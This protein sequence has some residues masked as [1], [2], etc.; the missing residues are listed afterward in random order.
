MNKEEGP[1]RRIPPDDLKGKIKEIK[2]KG[3]VKE[4]DNLTTAGIITTIGR[5]RA[6]ASRGR[7]PSAA[8]FLVERGIT[9]EALV[10]RGLD[11]K[12]SLIGP[13]RLGVDGEGLELLLPLGVDPKDRKKK[14][15]EFSK[16]GPKT[17]FDGEWEKLGYSKSDVNKFKEFNHPWWHNPETERIIDVHTKPDLLLGPGPTSPLPD[18]DEDTRD[19]IIKRLR[20]KRDEIRQGI[21]PP[22][23]PFGE[24]FQMLKNLGAYKP[25]LD[26]VGI[27]IDELLRAGVKNRHALM[28]GYSKN[29]I[30]EAAQRIKGQ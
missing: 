24:P 18:Y 13:K 16:E 8:D 4:I 6:L 17:V 11:R 14:I 3:G 2:V 12:H 1:K 7:I 20:E 26:E 27:T 5:A 19:G 28:L 23:K 25:G 29:Q 22:E 30:R 10:E 21:L 9:R 15:R